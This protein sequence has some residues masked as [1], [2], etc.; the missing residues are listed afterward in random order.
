ML[1]SRW[2]NEREKLGLDRSNI[3]IS[4][5]IASFYFV[6]SPNKRSKRV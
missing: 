4:I 2:P 1:Q 5:K 3:D 6:L